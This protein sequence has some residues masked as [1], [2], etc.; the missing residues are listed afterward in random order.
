MRKLKTIIKFFLA[1][2]AFFAA[3]DAVNI[4]SAPPRLCGSN[5]LSTEAI[6]DN[7]PETD[8]GVIDGY[9]LGQ[10]NFKTIPGQ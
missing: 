4:F 5:F 7:L 3:I 9:Q 2:F 8:A 10:M 1:L 6:L